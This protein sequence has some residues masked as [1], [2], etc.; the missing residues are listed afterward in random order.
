M[1]DGLAIIL[2]IIAMIFLV[3]GV[4]LFA[5]GMCVEEYETKNTDCHCECCVENE[6]DK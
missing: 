6:V 3:V 4:L 2:Y 1:N 5:A